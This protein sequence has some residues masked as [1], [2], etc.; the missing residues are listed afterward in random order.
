MRYW[1]EV[2]GRSQCSPAGGCFSPCGFPSPT[3]QFV[4][5]PPPHIPSLITPNREWA[6]V[7]LIGLAIF[8]FLAWA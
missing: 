8:V 4:H 6:V 2:I 1:K 5:I 7:L 3:S